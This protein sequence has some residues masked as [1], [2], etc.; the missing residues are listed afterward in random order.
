[1]SRRPPPNRAR[2]PFGALAALLTLAL[3]PAAARASGDIGCTPRWNLRHHDFTGCDSMAMLGPGNDT[4][5]NLALLLARRRPAPAQSPLRAPPSAPLFDWPTFEKANFPAAARL[6]DDDHAAG[7]GSRCL[8]DAAGAAAF[9]S[10]LAAARQV[11]DAE[12]ATLI[13][14]RRGLRP[15]C[16][17]AGG[18]GPSAA[19]PVRS[20]AA[21]AFAAYLG[22][23]GAFYAGDFAAA[24]AHFA[25]A[26]AGDD[27]WVRE[28]SRYMLARVEVNRAQVGLFDEYGTRDEKRAA[29]ARAITAAGAGLT[30]YLRAYPAGRYAASARGLRRRIYWLAGDTGKLAA[31]YAALLAQ[32]PAPRGLDDAALAEEIDTKLLPTLTSADTADPT[33]LAVLD[34]QAMR[35]DDKAG[36]AGGGAGKA[37]IARSDLD[38][39]RARFAGDPAL[40]DFLAAAHAFYVAGRPAD[41]LRLIPDAA[42]RPGF[43]AV[44]FS[45]Q[46]LR[47]M[48]LDAVGDRN[49]RGFWLDLVAGAAPSQRTAVEL[50]LALHD[51][52]TAGLDRVFAPGSPV[53]DATIR[54]IL[55]TDVAGMPLLRRQSGA[56]D[57]GAAAGAHERAVAL[58]TLLYKEVTRGAYRDFVA[59]VARVPAGAPATPDVYNF[60]GA[61]DPSTGI[62]TR[63]ATA[64]D[65]PCPALR[66][67]AARLVA[68][69]GDPAARLCV[70]EFVRLGGLDGF[71]LDTQPPPDEL[72]GTR[73]QF[74]GRPFSRLDTYRSL[75]AAP[76]T[77]PADRAYA[78]F[79]AVECYAP[80]LANG[81]GGEGVAPAV[82]KA[83]FER[84]RHDY[85]SSHWARELRYYW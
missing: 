55:L 4:R 29:D 13:A 81:C 38:A 73:A 62:F 31:E 32:P 71:F 82:R 63:G 80:S 78:L 51:E 79:R 52:R 64:G 40:F 45:R 77:P 14:A 75:I 1:M 11:T 10:A 34:L 7:E 21:R 9:A 5:V 26:T 35:G 17:D 22:G 83:W 33:L 66:A 19:T 27:P 46:M 36:A 50:A 2:L 57:L 42:R 37:A 44:Q 67:S 41:V 61:N 6:G 60:V 58:F 28:T 54:D 24:S 39:Q 43:D 68:D 72:G 85:P 59:D 70:A 23:A 48:A 8:S 56:T 3:W 49:A 12:R 15:T 18:A 69:A 74:P 76:G 53:R 84:L 30:A 65:Y 25:T 20:P 16:T 47:G